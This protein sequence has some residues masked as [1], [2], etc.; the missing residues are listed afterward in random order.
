M[1]SKVT[2]TPLISE[3]EQMQ[4]L[5]RYTRDEITAF[6]SLTGDANPLHHDRQAAERASFGEIIAS[7]QQTAS[8]MMGLVASHFSRSDDGVPREMLCLNFNFAFKS[9][10]FAEQDI[11]IVWRVSEIE[12]STSRGGFIGHVDGTASVAG[13]ACVVGR[14]T[15][16]VRRPSSVKAAA[17]AS[18]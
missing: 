1:D 7:G 17:A 14:G 13:K 10:V 8:R 4:A 6:A 18:R 2:A 16:L 3:G 5:V 9:P 15:V 12:R 11:R